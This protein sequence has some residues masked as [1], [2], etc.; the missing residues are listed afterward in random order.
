MTSPYHP[1]IQQFQAAA[2]LLDLQ[3]SAEGLS[4]ALAQLAS[5]MD[6]AADHLTDDDRAVL[7]AIG[8]LLYREGLQRRPPSS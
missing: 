6:L 2:E 4:D 1:T 3:A 5:W 8:G 7:I